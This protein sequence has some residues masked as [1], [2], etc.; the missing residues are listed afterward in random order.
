MKKLLHIGVALTLALAMGSAQAIP[1]S[2][3]IGGAN[4][5]AGDKLF[6]QF[7]FIFTDAS[8]A[9]FD[10]DPADIEVTALDDGGDDPGPGLAFSIADGVVGVVGD[11]LFAFT[12][13]TFGFRV[14]SLSGKLI[15]DVSMG[16]FDGTLLISNGGEQLVA[17]VVESIY[18]AAGNLLAE[19]QV[20]ESFVNGV[21][22]Y[23]GFDSA[24]FAPQREI[25]V[26][27]NI[28]VWSIAQG[29]AI[30]ITDFYQRFSQTSVPEPASLALL[31]L[32]LLGLG[33]ARR[34]RS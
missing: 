33:F 16:N 19:I 32:G 10:V 29:D 25:Y 30:Y 2:E 4:I 1:L 28:G 26:E 3:L 12:D 31:S 21:E 20:E 18:D 14:S 5:T 15:K 24:V 23:T 11:G 9:A 13:Y 27:K 6:D 22:T 8:D 7:E 17:T 34:R